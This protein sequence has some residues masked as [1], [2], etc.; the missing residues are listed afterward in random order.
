MIPSWSRLDGEK[1]TIWRFMTLILLLL[2]FY[3]FIS[4]LQMGQRCHCFCL[5]HK[6]CIFQVQVNKSDKP[7][8]T[9]DA[10]SEK[11]VLNPFFISCLL[12]SRWNWSANQEPN[13]AILPYKTLSSEALFSFSLWKSREDVCNI[14]MIYPWLADAQNLFIN[15]KPFPAALF[16][17][18]V[19]WILEGWIRK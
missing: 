4:T 13:F 10:N 16:W 15:T 7:K 5:C 19:S 2:C 14:M 6:I 3:R 12:M 17:V 9:D 11:K 1:K 8:K 18:W